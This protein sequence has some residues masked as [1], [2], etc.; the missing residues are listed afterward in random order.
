MKLVPWRLGKS[1]YIFESLD[2]KSIMRVNLSRDT[3]TQLLDQEKSIKCLNFSYNGSVLGRGFLDLVFSHMIKHSPTLEK[4]S[5]RG[6]CGH[7]SG[8]TLIRCNSLYQWAP[9]SKIS[10]KHTTLL[11]FP[12]VDEERR[13]EH[14]S[15]CITEVVH[16][17]L[18][19]SSV[20]IVLTWD[21]TLTVSITED[22]NLTSQRPSL[23][24]TLLLTHGWSNLT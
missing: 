4:W 7:C 6:S 5:S 18:N 10:N 19:M 23:D 9:L 2:Q 21:D 24:S 11:V 1:A 13:Q 3:S 14:C 17:V 8:L 12:S 22:H 20:P 15:T 16:A